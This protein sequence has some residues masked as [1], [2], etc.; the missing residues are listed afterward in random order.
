MIK[1]DA[2]KTAR[3]T[4]PCIIRRLSV[5]RIATSALA[6]IFDVPNS[7]IALP[8][9]INRGKIVMVDAAL[10]VEK[11]TCYLKKPF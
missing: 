8:M 9:N 2:A 1:R 4:M 5:P 7:N 10:S 3:E 11:V 6:N